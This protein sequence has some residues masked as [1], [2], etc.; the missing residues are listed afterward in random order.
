MRKSISVLLALALCLGLLTT[1]ALAEGPAV[2]IVN[3]GL[4]Y[5]TVEVT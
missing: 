1:G 2:T 4:E 3:E 5:G